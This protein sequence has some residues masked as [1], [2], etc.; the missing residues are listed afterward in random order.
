MTREQISGTLPVDPRNAFS[1]CWGESAR[2]SRPHDATHRL[3]QTEPSELGPVC[4]TFPGRMERMVDPA[5][6]ALGLRHEHFRESSSNKPNRE[7]G[8]LME[9]DETPAETET[10]PDSGAEPKP[11][12]KP[13][14]APETDQ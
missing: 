10:T 13:E 1:A 6:W 11:A 14:D 3:K 7:D 9:P 8:D 2:R 12:E 5:T 4:N